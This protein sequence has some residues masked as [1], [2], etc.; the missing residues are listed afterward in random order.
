MSDKVRQMTNKVVLTGKVTEFEKRTGT[1][2]NGESKGTPY[3]SFKGK[4]QFG[5]HKAMERSFDRYVQ[6]YSVKEGN[7]KENKAY[8]KTLAWANS[9]KSVASSNWDEA[10]EVSLQCS[11]ATN[12][13]VNA[14]EKLVEALGCSVAFINDVDGEY[15]ATADVEGYIQSI[16]PETKGE[17]K[18]ETGRLRVTILTNDFFGNIIPVK[19][20]IVPAELREAFEDGYEVGQTAKVF[21]TFELHKGEEKPKKT[22]GIGVQR[23]TDG[24]SYVEM[25]LTGADP[26]I[27]ED[28][29]DAYSKEAVRIGLAERKAALD[30][31]KEKGY[32]GNKGNGKSISSAST[33]SKPAPVADEDLP[34]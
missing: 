21:I 22:G 14:E 3:V 8:E 2:A 27:D 10:T 26:A 4:I 16:V 5:E 9:V 12:D 28:E 20:I 7:K 24:K 18:E 25:I 30:T 23:T 17:D 29:N 19:N 32:Q 15:G 13:Y 34:F 11:F 31:L 33:N 1:V 6:E